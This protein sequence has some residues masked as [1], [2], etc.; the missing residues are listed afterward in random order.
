MINL[1]LIIITKYEFYEH[2]NYQEIDK[3][4]LFCKKI[5]EKKVCSYIPIFKVYG[6][7]GKSEPLRYMCLMISIIFVLLLYIIINENIGVKNRIKKK[8]LQIEQNKQEMRLLKDNDINH[9]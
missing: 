1:N 2:V 5:L 6:E 7:F 9:L 3:L 8:L 4:N